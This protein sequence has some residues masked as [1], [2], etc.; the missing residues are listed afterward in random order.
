ML[1]ERIMANAN[2]M[3]KEKAWTGLQPIDFK[4][5][6]TV[7]SQYLDTVDTFHASLY[8]SLDISS[9]KVNIVGYLEF[10]GC[11]KSEVETVQNNLEG[12]PWTVASSRQ[13]MDAVSRKALTELRDQRTYAQAKRDSA[14]LKED[15]EKVK[16]DFEPIIKALE[17]E[18][19]AEKAKLHKLE[20]KWGVNS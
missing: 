11:T 10:I 4:E 9:Q 1:K 16:A 3:A 15:I 6:H 14:P 17:K 7:R 18:L 12:C 8:R 5:T 20:K 13:T 19:K 2:A